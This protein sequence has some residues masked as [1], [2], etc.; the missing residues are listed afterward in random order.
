MLEFTGMD[1]VL[2]ALGVLY[3][4]LAIGVVAFAIR[5]G[6]DKRSKIVWTAIAVAV[7]GFLPAKMLVEQ[8]QRNIYEKEAW[9]YFKKLC[10]EKSGE[11]IYKTFTGVKS[12]LVVK[13]LPPGKVGDSS[14]QFWHVFFIKCICP[15]M[16]RN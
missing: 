14:N 11:K 15:V 10:A 9:A 4:L 8:Y 12:V 2:R 7:F 1:I 16:S 3:W 13:P 5:K 6:K